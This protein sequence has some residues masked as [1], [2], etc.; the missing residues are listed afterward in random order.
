MGSGL[1]NPLDQK[2]SAVE[3]KKLTGPTAEQAALRGLLVRVQHS[4]MFIRPQ[5]YRQP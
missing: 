3:K 2:G 4:D 1:G 5:T